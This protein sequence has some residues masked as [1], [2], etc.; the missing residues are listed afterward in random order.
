LAGKHFAC[1]EDC[2]FCDYT[3]IYAEMSD[4]R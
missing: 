4:R 1:L 2:L 3:G